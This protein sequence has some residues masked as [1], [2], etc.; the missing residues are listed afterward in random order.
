MGQNSLRYPTKCTENHPKLVQNG[1]ETTQNGPKM[2]AKPL[3][4]AWIPPR[5]TKKGLKTNQNGPK[6]TA[7]FP[8]VVW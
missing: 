2:P 1:L 8:E 7:K 4:M 3:E 6:M 5:M